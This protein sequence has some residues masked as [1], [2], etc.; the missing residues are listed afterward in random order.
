MKWMALLLLV[1]CTPKIVDTHQ[2]VIDTRGVCVT[3]VIVKGP[4]GD[5]F[6]ADFE[7]VREMVFQPWPPEV[8]VVILS[9]V[10]GLFLGLRRWPWRKG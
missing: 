3:E 7:I 5:G 4:G 1:G 9:G 6:G 2:A 10:I 8:V